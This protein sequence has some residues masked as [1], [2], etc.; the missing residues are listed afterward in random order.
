MLKE[1]CKKLCDFK[2]AGI[3]EFLGCK[4]FTF[5]EM[6]NDSSVLLNN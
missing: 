6:L 1:L 4:S 5:I 2:K 3:H